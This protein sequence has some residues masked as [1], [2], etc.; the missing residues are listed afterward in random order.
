MNTFMKRIDNILFY[1][2]CF[3]AGI[4]SFMFQAIDIRVLAIISVT[5]II[6]AA[7]YDKYLFDDWALRFITLAGF[8]TALIDAHRNIELPETVYYVL[9]W[10]FFYILGKYI[11]TDKD[12]SEK[13]GFIA[14]VIMTIM[15]YIQGL[16]QYANHN[17]GLE[18]TDSWDGWLDFFTGVHMARTVYVFCF[19]AIAAWLFLGIIYLKKNML[20]GLLIIG[21]NIIAT[22]VDFVFARGRICLLTQIVVTFIMLCIYIIKE[23]KYKNKSYRK[24]LTIIGILAFVC[25]VSGMILV[26]LNVSGIGDR[27]A[28]S[29]LA[30]DGGIFG[31]VRY[32]SIVEGLIL[33]VQQP[34]GGW[35]TPSLDIAHNV[36][37]LFSRD[38]DTVIF[39]LL[40]G[41]E[42]VTLVY[43][44]RLLMVKMKV[45]DYVIVSLLVSINIY[46]TIETCPWRYRKYWFF[47]LFVGGIL[48][49]RVENNRAENE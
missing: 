47:I 16:I 6:Y 5:F 22:V 9:L 19:C 29:F 42:I 36:F 41:Y 27:Y 32:R 25:L 40:V 17:S 11:M 37:L 49:K 7:I 30:R 14:L 1:A 26:K 13:R 35:S 39:L 45:L 10:P 23:K 28:N 44:I 15:I 18:E 2:I 38:Y 21:L 31:N 24:A 43:L 33:S 34:L 4:Y 3:F 46:Y 12:K 48:R 8:G 20:I